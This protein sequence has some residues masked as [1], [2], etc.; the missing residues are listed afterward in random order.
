MNMKFKL[1]IVMILVFL[2][3]TNDRSNPVD[4]DI[5][6]GCIDDTACNYNPDANQDDSSCEYPVN[7]NVDCDG[8]CNMTSDDDECGCLDEKA[9]NYNEM[10]ECSFH[11][12]REDCA[13][14]PLYCTDAT[15]CNYGGKN[16]SC[17]GRSLCL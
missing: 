10:G 13:G 8:N 9:C 3:C 17:L 6:G 5:I 11:G 1:F 4:P 16:G 12:S 15:A 7:E 14:E 2:S